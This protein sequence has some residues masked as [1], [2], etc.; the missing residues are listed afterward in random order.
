[1]SKHHREDIFE[2]TMAKRVPAPAFR[3]LF[4]QIKELIVERV[5]SGEWQAGDPL[6]SEHEF[7]DYYNVS[8]G[9]VRKAIAEMATENLVERY[10]GKG[11][12]V[13]SHTDEREH[14]RFFHIVGNDGIKRL[15]G[16]QALSCQRGKATKEN[17]E[18][19]GLENGKTVVIAERLRLID[20]VPI[21][22]ETITI[23]DEMFPGFSEAWNGEIPNEFY[24]LYETKYG[25]RVVSAKERLSVITAT[26][27]VADL[28][29]LSPGSP[30][31]KID[32]TAYT[33]GEQPVERRVS[34]CNTA[35]FHYQSLLS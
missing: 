1:M 9:T 33:F 3:P 20:D 17:Q 19:L 2:K 21:I 16:S 25:T 14:S 30:L 7:A 27:R 29:G 15:P 6:P 35:N 34:L 13:A 22:L 31:L 12:F 32:R 4:A 11:T 18:I 5:R 28:L 8:Q 10:R 26:N 24:P 23:S